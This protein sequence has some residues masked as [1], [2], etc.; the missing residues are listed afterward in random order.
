MP[1]IK[2]PKGY[3]SSYPPIIGQHAYFDSRST[4]TN[5]HFLVKTDESNGKLRTCHYSLSF[6]KDP[7]PFIICQGIVT[8]LDKEIKNN[9]FEFKN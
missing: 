6:K 1:Q 2:S 3:Y 8:E 9:K 5:Y 7:E 4:K